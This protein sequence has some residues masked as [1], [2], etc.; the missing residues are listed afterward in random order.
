MASRAFLLET[1]G[2]YGLS[3]F[4][5]YSDVPYH[6]P[7]KVNELASLNDWSFSV[8]FLNV[9]Y[10]AGVQQFDQTFAILK[11]TSEFVACESDDH[12]D[13]LY[14]FSML[15]KGWIGACL[16]ELGRDD[17]FDDNGAPIERSF[18]SLFAAP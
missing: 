4:P 6:S 13:R 12:P 14:L 10:A 3:M 16:P 7:V 5:G 2:W 11:E 9:A 17:L 18:L 1:G 15:T 8:E